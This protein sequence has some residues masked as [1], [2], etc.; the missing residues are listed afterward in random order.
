[1][2]GGGGVPFGL[3]F[4]GFVAGGGSFILL[5]AEAK[6]SPSC[7][8]ALTNPPMHVPLPKV[9]A[10]FI[11]LRAEGPGVPSCSGVFTNPP[12]YFPLL[13]VV[14]PGGRVAAGGSTAFAVH[15]SVPIIFRS[16]SGVG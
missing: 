6:G 7:L 16:S 5:R 2:Y 4:R 9:V 12:I 3:R 10:P 8:G 11:L 1:M 14:V 15:V 13:E